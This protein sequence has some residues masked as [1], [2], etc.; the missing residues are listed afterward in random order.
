ML[1]Q[2][3]ENK[4]LEIFKDFIY[5][6][7]NLLCNEEIFLAFIWLFCMAVEACQLVLRA[8]LY[9]RESD[10]F[11]KLEII[12]P[13]LFYSSDLSFLLSCG[14]TFSFLLLPFSLDSPLYSV[15]FHYS[16]ALSPM[17]Y[18]FLLMT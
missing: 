8:C 14:I 13:I 18:P 6:L 17:N 7:L 10:P 2:R 5:R 15:L 11:G 16:S 9:V 4:C 1:V 12:F 3:S